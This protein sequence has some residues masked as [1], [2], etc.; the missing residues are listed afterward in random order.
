M[1]KIIINLLKLL[2][3]IKIIHWQTE[4]FA[5]HKTLDKAYDKLGDL[6]DKLVEVHQGKYG[7]I[8]YDS[9]TDIT[10]VNIEDITIIEVLEQFNGYLTVEFDKLTDNL[11]DSDTLN[12]RDEILGEV[13]RIRYLLTLK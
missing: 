2:N 13:N 7:R 9:P 3:Q 8:K 6:L 1:N 11:K 10:I 12:I 5:E 4:S